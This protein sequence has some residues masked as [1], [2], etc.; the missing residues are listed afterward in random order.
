[1]QVLSSEK[2][3]SVSSSGVIADIHPHVSSSSPEVVDDSVDQFRGEV[4]AK[5]PRIHHL[6]SNPCVC[7]KIHGDSES[8]HS[9]AD[10]KSGELVS[11]FPPCCT[12][13]PRAPRVQQSHS[14]TYM[15][16]LGIQARE[17]KRFLPA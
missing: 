13:L 9:A 7:F 17:A 2:Q 15:H 3:T 6:D 1:M 16:D 14:D 5:R 12:Q 4:D 10:P 11:P 8:E